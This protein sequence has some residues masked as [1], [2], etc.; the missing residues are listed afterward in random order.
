MASDVPIAL[1]TGASSG[2]GQA[3]ANQLAGSGFRVYGTS[4]HSSF[5]PASFEPLV[6]DV[7]SDESVRNGVAR[8]VG[9]HARI[10]CVV[11]SAGYG[12]GGSIEDS[13][14]EEARQQFDTNLFGVLRVCRE[15]LPSMRQQRTGVIIN[16]SS[17]AG[18]FGL[19]F[20]GL[21]SA[22]KFALEGLTESLRLETR[23]F[24][25]F[26]VLVEPGDVRT[27]ITNNRVFARSAMHSAYA[28]RCH[29]AMTI[30][31][32]DEARGISPTR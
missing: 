12:L 21:Y 30:A 8:I 28:A 17:L 23:A 5:R 20:Q 9:E 24:G 4:R 15:V 6:M 32:N 13:S 25:I 22:S 31:A 2:I 26:V 27:A 3:C 29:G 19:P 16:I 1:V 7:T 10:D 14:L 18:L 11:N